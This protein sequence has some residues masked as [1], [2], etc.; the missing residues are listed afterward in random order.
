MDTIVFPDTDTTG[1]QGKT[2]IIS[3]DENEE[4]TQD[5]DTAVEEI[6][7]PSGT[8][9]TPT[10]NSD[11]PETNPTQ[12]DET[13]VDEA[14]DSTVDDGTTIENEES[15]DD[16]NEPTTTDEASDDP[17][18]PEET[19]VIEV[20]ETNV[21]TEC[22]KDEDG[23]CWKDQEPEPEVITLTEQD[24]TNIDM[25]YNFAAINST[26][27]DPMLCCQSIVECDPL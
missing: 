11:G 18:D 21:T 12:P 24:C 7:E 14:D 4:T 9:D 22:E 6:V 5:E 15:P 20:P 13:T 26:C 10:E 27:I 23:F 16:Q 8:D 2:K 25:F 19:L 3:N 17:S 1:D